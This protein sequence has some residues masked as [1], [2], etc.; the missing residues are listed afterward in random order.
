MIKRS[1]SWFLAWFLP[2]FSVAC[3]GGGSGG[4]SG[5]GTGTSTSSE[6]ITTTCSMTVTGDSDS[7][8]GSHTYESS[9]YGADPYNLAAAVATGVAVL[10]APTSFAAHRETD[11]SGTTTAQWSLVLG[12]PP[13][14][15]T[16]SET[17]KNYGLVQVSYTAPRWLGELLG[18]PGGRRRSGY[19]HLRHFLRLVLLSPRRDV[20]HVLRR[21]RVRPCKLPRV[22]SRLREY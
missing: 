14:P 9:G 22:Q 19:V 5:G 17:T 13:A 7:G 20:R 1:T 6:P 2:A 3:G 12:G 16:F 15:D 8:I 11:A 10:L 21:S 18:Q 4:G